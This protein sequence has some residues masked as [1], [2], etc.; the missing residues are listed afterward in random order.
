MPTTHAHYRHGEEVQKRV[1]PKAREIIEKYPELFHFG[2]HGPDLLFY[3]HA[4]KKNPINQLGS[5]IHRRSGAE[6]FERAKV[7]LEELSEENN[8]DYRA[9]LAYV[10][11]FLCHFSLDVCCHGYIREKV[12]ESGVTHGEIEAE[13]DRE[14]LVRE[15]LDPVS[16]I[17]TGHLMPSG[18]NAR[19]ISR[20][21]EGIGQE[22]IFKAMKDMVWYLN[23]LVLPG[24]AKRGVILALLKLV[25]QY[26]SKHG[27]IINY[28]K[29]PLCEDSTEK[30]LT[31][32]DDA[33]ELAVKLIDEFPALSDE[34]YAYDF[35]SIHP[36]DYSV[37]APKSV[38]EQEENS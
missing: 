17:L 29:N 15:G 18:K 27:L 34:V 13:L 14:L 7:V 16:T 25:G 21:F 36:G 11:G 32:F 38:K 37:Y 33:V 22:D 26:E 4:L 30:L 5:A 31:L 35:G 8:G 1:S 20:F 12:D 2:V 24:K 28:E 23:M 10:Y 9:S 6:F 3:Y 19:V